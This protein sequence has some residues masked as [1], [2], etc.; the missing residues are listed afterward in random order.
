MQRKAPVRRGKLLIVGLLLL[1]VPVLILV[2][3]LG[4]LLVAEGL[5]LGELSVVEL[6]ELYVVEL[7]LSAAGAYLL[8]RLLGYSIDSHL[9]GTPEESEERAGADGTGDDD[10][11]GTE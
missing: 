6:L 11:A 2:A 7:L 5:V 4:F 9:L 8:F 3:T 1:F 10:A